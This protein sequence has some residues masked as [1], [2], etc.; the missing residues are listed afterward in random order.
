MTDIL[1]LPVAL[2]SDGCRRMA[3]RLESDAREGVDLGPRGAQIECLTAS[4]S[5]SLRELG[6]ALGRAMAVLPEGDPTLCG[7]REAVSGMTWI[8]H[9][10]MA[11]AARHHAI[12]VQDT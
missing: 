11:G 7:L 3:V 2:S 10:V 12:P 9:L 8:A 6:E 1:T 5:R 4:L